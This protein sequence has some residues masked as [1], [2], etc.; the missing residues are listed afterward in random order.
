MKYCDS[1]ITGLSASNSHSPL[2]SSSTYLTVLWFKTKFLTLLSPGKN[3][4]AASYRLESE[5]ELC[6]F[7]HIPFLSIPAD[8]ILSPLSLTHRCLSLHCLSHTDVCPSTVSH[9]QMPVLPL[10]LHTD[11]CPSTVPHTQMSV[12]PLSLHTDANPDVTNISHF[13]LSPENTASFSF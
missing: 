1:L 10:S 13:P 12:P 6:F 3:L 2:I 11:A 8:D 9:T 7:R 5:S 4:L